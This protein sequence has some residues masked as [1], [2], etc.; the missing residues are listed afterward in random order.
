MFRALLLFALL[1]PAGA[2]ASAHARAPVEPL[3]LEVPP[4]PPRVIDP[5]PVEPPPI[6]LVED[7]AAPAASSP[8]VPKPRPQ[9]RDANRPESK[10]EVKPETPEPEAVP[11]PAPI[12]PLRTGTSA[13]GPEAERQIRDTLSRA[14]K[15]LETVDVRG[16][17]EDRKAAYDSVK[18][19]ISRAVEALKASNVVVAR[20]LADRAENIARLLISR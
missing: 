10:P 7:L 9:N 14:N 2:C 16:L 13:N 6:P 19:S 4:A 20:S 5:A 17:S 1:L 3:S 8:T 18:D 12:A 15:L 11:P